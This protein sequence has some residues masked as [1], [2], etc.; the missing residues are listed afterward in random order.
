M[1]DQK[2]AQLDATRE[3]LSSLESQLSKKDYTFTEQKRLLKLMKEEYQ[4]KLKATDAKYSA[5]KAIILRLEETIFELYKN[6]SA[7]NIS[8]PDSD[9]TGMF[10]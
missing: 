4:E 10:N 6:K 5:Q 7:V 9:K 8:N 1:L 2:S 3:R